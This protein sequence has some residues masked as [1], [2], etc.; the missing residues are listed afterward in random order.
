M[1][2]FR[3]YYD[4]DA[5]ESW[6]NTMSRKGWAFKKFFLGF[7]S[8]EECEPGEYNYQIDI[9]NSWNG[10]KTDF[11]S[12]MEESGVEVISQWYRWVYIRKKASDGPFEMY[13]DIESKIG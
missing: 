9:L 8:F 4:K 12:F 5:E 6:L 2:K 13:T 11:A 10:D 1:T 7:Y 3:L